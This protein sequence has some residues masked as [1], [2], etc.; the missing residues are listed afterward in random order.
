MSVRWDPL[1]AAAL[2]EELSE[3]LEGAPVWGVLLDGGPRRAL[4]YSEERTIAF[5]L[6]PLQGWVIDLPTS[7][8]LPKPLPGVRPLRTRVARVRPLE[9][10]SAFVIQLDPTKRRGEALDL[11][12]ELS[13]NLFNAVLVE[14]ESRAIRQ[15]LVPRRAG[16][17]VVVV[18][19]LYAPPASTGRRQ[20]QDAAEWIE[21]GGPHGEGVERARERR[22]LDRVAWTS[23]MNVAFLGG[24]DGFERWLELTS[25]G[26]WGAFLLPTG[27]GPQPYPVSLGLGDARSF[28][29]LLE[30]FAQARAASSDAPPLHSLS[31][32]SAIVERLEE[33]IRRLRS[34]AAGLQ[35]QLEAT[36]DPGALRSAGDLI[37]AR[38]SEILPGA[39]RVV[40]EGL[41]GAPREIAL[42][43][44]LRPEENA[45]RRYAEAA[46][47]EKARRTLPSRIE[48]A[49]ARAD[50]WAALLDWLRDGTIGPEEVA[51]ALGPG[52]RSGRA[53]KGAATGS[54]PYNQYRTTGGLEVR[55]GRSARRNDEL[56]FHYSSP[57]DVWLHA[58]QVPGAHVILRW[59][60]KD[61]PSGRDLVEAAVLAAL[62][63][64]A[65]HSG[66][67]AVTWT[68]RKHVRKPR[69]S[70]LGSVVAERS[71]TIFVE[72]DPELAG[73]L[74]WKED[75][76]G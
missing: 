21:L 12:I 73:R 9:D 50:R 75:A 31:V 6:H 14:R 67:V 44:T 74:A 59:N 3:A 61:N 65:R 30:A 11:V 62:H 33:R 41:D 28:P 15:V 71:Q 24:P 23:S 13:G 49:R 16:R 32:P 29:S 70:A 64:E 55:V 20:P 37:L 4:L 8:P 22:I 48:D 57:D 46:R 35:R 52:K 1:L 5:E 39:D 36:G 47:V 66:S 7:G 45:D 26:S 10:E 54:L 19:A 69:K 43:P 2:A 72:P 18:G 68:R 63:S 56:T 53:G 25:T 51:D 42:D 40:V 76:R 27:S 17:R 38:F 58:E 34:K 60:R